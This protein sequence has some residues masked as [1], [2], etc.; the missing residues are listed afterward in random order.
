MK[1]IFR[2]YKNFRNALKK[3]LIFQPI[4]TYSLFFYAGI[5][6]FGES[7]TLIGLALLSSSLTN[8]ALPGP[9]SKVVF[10]QSF[11][12]SSIPSEKSILFIIVALIFLFAFF[13]RLYFLEKA[14]NYV[15]DQRHF[16]SRAQLLSELEIKYLTA[17]SEDTSSI[18]RKILSEVDALVFTFYQPLTTIFSSLFNITFL[19]ISLIFIEGIKVLP[20]ASFVFILFIILFIKNKR[21][22][23]LST[24][25]R[26]SGNQARFDSAIELINARKEIK[27]YENVPMFMN[28]FDTASKDYSK[29]MANSQLISQTPRIYIEATILIIFSLFLFFKTLING[30]INFSNENN[31]TLFVMFG[32]VIFRCSQAFQGLSHGFTQ[33]IIGIKIMEELDFKSYERIINKSVIKDS[34]KINIKEKISRID[35]KNL[36]LQNIKMN[37]PIEIEVKLGET[38]IVIGSSGSGKSTLLNSILGFQKI[39]LGKINFIA[40]NNNKI[41]SEKVIKQIGYVNQ[42]PFIFNSSIFDN[43]TLRDQSINK[44][45]YE[46]CLKIINSL[47]LKDLVNWKGKE[48]RLGE[49]GKYISGGQKQKI[50]IARALFKKPSIIILDEPTSALDKKNTQVVCKAIQSFMKESIIIISSHDEISKYFKNTKIINLDNFYKK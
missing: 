13:S 25:K 7:S 29:A 42:D 5:A 10:L 34:K 11:V 3:A 22:I 4:R 23:K 46:Y 24:L 8:A 43:I 39:S 49:G 45:D 35:T 20:L 50:A 33:L 32:F 41:S 38:L 48:F 12:D 15:H 36:F 21:K 16:C 30:D 17:A 44:K 14:S 31:T 40:A 18:A 1:L 28:K 26:N 9:L 27:I 6:S 19:I 37:L 47:D 2:E